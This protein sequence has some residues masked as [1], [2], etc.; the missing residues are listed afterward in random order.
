MSR[1]AIYQRLTEI[2]RDV[3]DDDAITATPGLT[4]R[5][6]AGWDSLAHLRIMLNAEQAFHINFAASQISGLQ[7]VGELVALI[8]SKLPG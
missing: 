3:F 8:E 4:A 5:D 2:L 6:V 1:D 7:N